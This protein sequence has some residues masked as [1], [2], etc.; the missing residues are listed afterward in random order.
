M[1]RISNRQLVIAFLACRLSAE[2]MTIPGEMAR[3]GTD[4][5]IV[6]LLAKLVVALLYLPVIFVTLKFS[7][8]S[9]IT[10]AMRKNK[11]FGITA[12]VIMSVGNVFLCSKAF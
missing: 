7:G 3:Y 10:A 9:V 12:G 2:M 11:A 4:R 8:D 5:F 1:S 6:I